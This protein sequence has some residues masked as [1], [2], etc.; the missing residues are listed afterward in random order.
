MTLASD[1]IERLTVDF[2]QRS[3]DIHIGEGIIARAGEI[4]KPILAAP[5]AIVV[6]DELVAP[7]WLQPLSESLRAA[8]I[9][10]RAITLPPGEHTKSMTELGALLGNLLSG[11]IDRKTTLIALGGG[12]IGDLTGF[13]A[14]IALR[15]VD[16]VQVP[17]TLLSQVDSS[18]GGKTGIDTPQGKNLIGAFHQPRAVLADTGALNTLP[19]RELLCGYAEVVKYGVINDRPFFDWLTEH[20]PAM[21]DG[22]PERRRETILRSC[23]NKARIVAADEREAGLR[24]LLN[25]GHTFGHAIEAEVG[26][27]DELKHGEA[28][29]IGMVMAMDLSVRLDLCPKKDS[30]LVRAHLQA[31]GLPVTL[32]GLARQGWS[33]E[34]LLDHMGRD[35]KTEGG[36]LTFILTRGIGQSFV[37]RD[38]DPTAVA[39]LLSDYIEDARA[40]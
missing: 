11:G 38:V 9:A 31:V 32:K 7:H 24:A 18:V 27:G 33:A 26:F 40:A 16:F 2:G 34:R 28:V 5:R 1:G 15:G 12:V 29:G 23:T 8:G 35:K 3:Y 17:T 4:L 13:A 25:L 36:K 19:K 30:D 37:A 20:G 10:H 21:I 39:N 14:A 6:T 22:D